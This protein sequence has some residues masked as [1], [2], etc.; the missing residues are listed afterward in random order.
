MSQLLALKQASQG[1]TR[2]LELGV[3]ENVEKLMSNNNVQ[4]DRERE[5]KGVLPKSSP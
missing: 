4:S 2:I 1:S 5:S 3:K